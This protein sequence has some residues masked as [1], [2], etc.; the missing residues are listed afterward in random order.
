MNSVCGKAAVAFAAS[1]LFTG[2]VSAQVRLRVPS[3]NFNA[4]EIIRAEVV[5][6]STNPVSYCVMF[7]QQSTFAG[8][9][10]ATPIPFYVERRGGGSWHVLQ[11]G[12]DLGSLRHPVTLNPGESHSFPF[13]LNDT[14]EMRLSLYYWTGERNDVCGKSPKGRKTT[15]SQP[16]S[17]VMK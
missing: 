10:E 7:G 4:E 2:T 8:T 3:V 11:N 5:N 16:F 14:G 17:L 13:S 15:R 9:H 1:I 6:E 12:P